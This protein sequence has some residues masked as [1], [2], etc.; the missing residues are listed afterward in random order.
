VIK[1]SSRLDGNPKKHDIKEE[2]NESISRKSQSSIHK[3]T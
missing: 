1:E 2:G 3:L